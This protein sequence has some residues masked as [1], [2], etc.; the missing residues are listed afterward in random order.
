M[1]TR[2]IE[3][4]EDVAFQL[5]AR[6]TEHGLEECRLETARLN[7]LAEGR[8]AALHDLGIV[9][10]GGNV[11]TAA[12]DRHLLRTSQVS[13]VEAVYRTDAGD[14]LGLYFPIWTVGAVAR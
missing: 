2:V 6:L 7:I 1:V 11:S 10:G 9:S 13:W 3:E 14:S 5:G 4:G 8:F 12:I